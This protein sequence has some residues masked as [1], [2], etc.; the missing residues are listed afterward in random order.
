MTLHH[1]EKTDKTQESPNAKSEI[2]PM[3]SNQSIENIITHDDN[4]NNKLVDSRTITLEILTESKSSVIEINCNEMTD[5]PP[6][7]TFATPDQV[8]NEFQ[9]QEDVDENVFSIFFEESLSIQD[10]SLDFLK[11][12]ID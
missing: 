7:E 3:E 2:I 1:K 6:K 9:G 10:M 8:E 12:N 11:L 4:A 5:N